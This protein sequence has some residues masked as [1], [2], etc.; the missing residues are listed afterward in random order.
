MRICIAI[1][2]IILSGCSDSEDAITPAE[3]SN[4]ASKKITEITTIDTDE[5][6]LKFIIT[7]EASKSFKNK[8]LTATSHKA[9]AQSESGAWSWRSNRTSEKNARKSA[10]IACQANNKKNES[11]HPCKVINVNGEWLINR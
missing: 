9:F 11:L 7:N 8:Y 6:N 4:F 1:I 10:L 3:D 5:L 2:A